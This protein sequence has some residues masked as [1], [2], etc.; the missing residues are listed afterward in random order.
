MR[1]KKLDFEERKSMGNGI[2]EMDLSALIDDNLTWFLTR[3]HI[4]PTQILWIL[5]DTVKM[6]MFFWHFWYINRFYN[7]VEHQVSIRGQ[8][9]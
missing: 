8:Q 9:T 1:K 6:F 3:A 7:P 5:R 4:M 2:L